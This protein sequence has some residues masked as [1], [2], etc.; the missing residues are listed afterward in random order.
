MPSG[1]RAM[2]TSVY[3]SLIY[4]LMGESGSNLKY[5]VNE[6]YN[7]NSN[8]WSTRLNS[9]VSKFEFDAITVGDNIYCI[10]GISEYGDSSSN[11]CYNVLTNTWSTKKNIPNITGRVSSSLINDTIFVMSNSGGILQCEAYNTITDTWVTKKDHHIELNY[12][13]SS[14]NLKNNIYVFGGMNSNEC[15]CYIV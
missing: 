10:G 15:E 12:G 2:G 1:R 4:L 7:I 6:C 13:C 3:N 11:E 14:S 9:P 8:T 5:S